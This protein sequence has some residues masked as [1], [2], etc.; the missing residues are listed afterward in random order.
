MV[1]DSPSTRGSEG[2]DEM[3]GR[4]GKMWRDSKGVCMCVSRHLFGCVNW[5]QR[6]QES[7][8][9]EVREDVH[10]VPYK[11]DGGKVAP[12]ARVRRK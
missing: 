7:E 2:W 1:E 5:R 10:V 4:G 12:A 6:L 9:S 8:K 3:E 11:P